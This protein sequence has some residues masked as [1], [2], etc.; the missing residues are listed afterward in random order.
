MP[1]A[2]IKLPD[3]TSVVIEGSPEEVAKLLA[4]YGGASSAPGTP[5]RPPEKKAKKEAKTQKTAGHTTPKKDTGVTP[6]LPKVINLIKT[7]DEAEVIEVK[8]LDKVGQVNRILLP[9]Y[10]VHEHLNN[11]HGLTT[12]EVSQIT[13]ELG[14]PVHVSNVS[15]TLS[16]T[17]SK[18][19]IADRIRKKG[20]PVRYKISR[21]G[22]TYFN[23]VLRGKG[24][25]K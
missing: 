5:A 24:D 20:H 9:L 18:Y 22:V 10:V 3:G 17:A 8:I 25:G 6:D 13:K 14:I 7:C 21:R 16:G 12:G 1:K 19:V 15:H 11:A 4:L 2:S 23:G